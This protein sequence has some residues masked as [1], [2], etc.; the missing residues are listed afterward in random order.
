VHNA[1]AGIDDGNPLARIIDEHLV[2]GHVMLTHDRRKSPLEL[3][4]QI[5]EPTVAVTVRLAL[6]ILLPQHHQAHAGAL[7]LARQRSPIRL[8]ASAQT[9]LA[10]DPREQPLLEHVVSQLGR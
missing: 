6:P 8:A 9:R 2:A 4:E 7:E 10:T 5:A 1:G 3:T